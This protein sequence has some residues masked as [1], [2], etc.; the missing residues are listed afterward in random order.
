MEEM[1]QFL[2][3]KK[4]SFAKF[5]GFTSTNPAKALKWASERQKRLVEWKENLEILIEE[6]KAKVAEEGDEKLSKTANKYSLEELEAMIEM[7]KKK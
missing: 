2:S 6:L 5:G 3:N 4:Q 7:K 1:I